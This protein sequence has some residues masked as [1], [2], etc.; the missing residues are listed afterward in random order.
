M[1]G[2]RILTMERGGGIFSK[3][4]GISQRAQLFRLWT[5]KLHSNKWDV[6]HEGCRT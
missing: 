5:K 3:G 2:V 6:G 1:G 4:G